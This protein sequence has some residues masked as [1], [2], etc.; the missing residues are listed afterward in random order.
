[1]ALCCSLDRATAKKFVVFLV[2]DAYMSED[3]VVRDARKEL[4]LF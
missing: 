1:M 4:L 2:F 3:A